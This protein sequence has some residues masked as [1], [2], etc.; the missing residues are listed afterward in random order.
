MSAPR[1]TPLPPAPL[2]PLPVSNP[3]P[4]STLPPWK[5]LSPTARL[6]LSQCLADLVARLRASSAATGMEERDE[7]GSLT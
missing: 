2:Q 3:P 4:H 5:Q 1:T 7:A 6:Q